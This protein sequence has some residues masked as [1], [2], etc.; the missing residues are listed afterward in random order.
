MSRFARITMPVVQD[1]TGPGALVPVQ[2]LEAP[3]VQLVGLA[4][5]CSIR[6]EASIDGT[7]WLQLINSANPSASDFTT[8]GVY[9]LVLGTTFGGSCGESPLVY[10][11]TNR[12][13]Q[14]TGNPVVTLGARNVRT[15]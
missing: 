3:S 6:I 9:R 5:G 11:R 8:D 4:G 10:M 2:D 12:T 15:D 13:V 7:N 14:G 1:A